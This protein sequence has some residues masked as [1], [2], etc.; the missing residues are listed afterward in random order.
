MNNKINLIL[1]I[2]SYAYPYKGRS[3]ECWL[4]YKTGTMASVRN[5]DLEPLRRPLWVG[6]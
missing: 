4:S 6:Y 1:K 2:M 5:V 3:F